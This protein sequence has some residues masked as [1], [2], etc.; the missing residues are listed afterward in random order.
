MPSNFSAIGFPTR[1][2][3][4][5]DELI[6]KLLDAENIDQCDTEK[7]TYLRWKQ[8]K[9]DFGPEVFF[10]VVDNEIFSVAPF[11]R[12][13]S[14][15]SVGINGRID[16]PGAS[17]LDTFLHAW[18]E[19][20]NDD[21]ES[22]AYPFVFDM[23]SYLA[24]DTG[25]FPFFN[26]VGVCAIV[27]ELEIFENEKAY[28]KA[29]EGQEMV[30]AVESF[31]PSGLFAPEPQEGEKEENQN[32][33]PAPLAIFTGRIL[34][35]EKIKNELTGHEFHWALVRTL[36][37]TFDVVMDPEYVYEPLK[38]DGIISGSFYLIADFKQG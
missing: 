24:Y 1:T 32:F 20:E 5:F 25:D 21:P 37:G 33:V 14:E 23:V 2:P 26:K 19:P 35:T 4:D 30:M 31:I 3:G 12:G 15:V 28:D 7:G 13:K 6:G 22:G 11:F 16:V 34:E 36:G 29:R 27:Q 9:G 18:A 38:K 8:G 17:P 10:Q